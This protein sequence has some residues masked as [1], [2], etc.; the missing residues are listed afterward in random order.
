[1]RRVS[2]LML[3]G[4]AACAKGKAK[5][6]SDEHVTE[7]RTILHDTEAAAGVSPLAP[8]PWTDPAGHEFYHYSKAWMLF[9]R[10]GAHLDAPALAAALDYRSAKRLGGYTALQAK[11]V[12]GVSW[13]G[14]LDAG[15]YGAPSRRRSDAT[16]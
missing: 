14:R 8:A 12:T 11:G 9:D 3:L 5:S 13:S 4:C 1:M 6:D 10:N 7:R 16:T 2:I 15:A